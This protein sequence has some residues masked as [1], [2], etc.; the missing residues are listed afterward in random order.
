MMKSKTSAL[1]KTARERA[2]LTQ[3]ELGR[4][5]GFTSAQFISNVER[6]LAP[7]PMKHAMKTSRLL[8]IPVDA[9]IKAKAQDV[10]V[11]LTRE[12]ASYGGAKKKRVS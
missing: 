9:I 3:M 11:A 6:G 5:L 7:F 4:A 12:A 8:K 2:G 10:T 1:I